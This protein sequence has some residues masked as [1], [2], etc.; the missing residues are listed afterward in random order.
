MIE[1]TEK[2]GWTRIEARGK[3]TRE[4]GAGKEAQELE[5]RQSTFGI[6]WRRQCGTIGFFDEMMGTRIGTR[7]G[8]EEKGKSR[9]TVVPSGLLIFLSLSSPSNLQ[10]FSDGSM[11]SVC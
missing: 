3:Q 7:T 1:I 11:Q 5:Q 8:L 2:L 10:M 4:Q 6:Y 9:R